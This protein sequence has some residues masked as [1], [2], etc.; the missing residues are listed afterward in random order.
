LFVDLI[1]RNLLYIPVER[2]TLIRLSLSLLLRVLQSAAMKSAMLVVTVLLP[3]L[4]NA[5]SFG[6]DAEQTTFHVTSVRSEEAK[7]WCET[8]KCSATRIIVE[9]YTRRGCK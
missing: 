7:D 8:G 9:G 4:L 3:L 2:E 1:W 6:Q 5:P